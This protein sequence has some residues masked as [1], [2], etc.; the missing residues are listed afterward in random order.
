M[1]VILT[2][3]NGSRPVGRLPLVSVSCSGVQASAMMRR[4]TFSQ[5]FLS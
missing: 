5:R 2:E 1:S 4:M 3:T